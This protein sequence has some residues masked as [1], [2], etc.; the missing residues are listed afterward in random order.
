MHVVRIAVIVLTVAIASCSGGTG[1]PST[2]QPSYGGKA[3]SFETTRQY[4]VILTD[5]HCDVCTRADKDHLLANSKIM[6]RVIELIGQAEESIEVAQF[7]FSRTQI[8]D[9]LLEA[10]NNGVEVR[11][12][13]N[14]GQQGRD[15]PS[16]R[17]KE[18]G[19]P[20]RFVEGKDNGSYIGLQHAKY[21]I[22]DDEIVVMGS[23]NWSSTG[24]S[25]NEENTIVLQSD[26]DDPM[27][28]AFRCYFEHMYNA[29]LQLAAGCSNDEVR[30]TPSTQPW[31]MIRDEIRGAQSSVD[32]LMHHMT[33]DDAVK[34]LAKAAEN[35]RRV[36]VI[37]NAEDIDETRGSRWDRLRA[38]GGEIRYKQTNSDLYQFMHDK[39]AI[40]DGQVL[41]GGSGNWSG[42]AFFNNYEFYT[43]IDDPGVLVPFNGLFSRL[44][45]WSLTEE[46]LQEGRTAR[47]QD[48]LER[49]IYFGN[50][51]AHH[52]STQGED[53]LD[54]GN[55][56]REIDGET[57][58]ASVE[59]AGDPVRHAFEYAR[60]RGGLDFMALSPHVVDDRADDPPD[61]ASMTREGYQNIIETA[62]A[63]TTES[64]GTFVALPSFEWS[65]NSLGNHVNVLGSAEISKVERGDFKTFYE[66]F[67]ALRRDEGDRAYLM[68]NHPRTFRHP[69]NDT[70]NGSWDQI[71]GVNLQEI[72]RNS[73]RSKKFN[74]YGLDDYEP[75]ASV[76]P[77]WIAGE[78]MPD[79]S[80]VRE[81][82]GNIAQT[83][84]AHHRL[85]EVTINRGSGLKTEMPV[86]PSIVED[87]ETGELERYIKVHSD[88]DY[89]LRNGF[90]LAPVA[91][92]DNH[93]A[94]W[95]TAHTS[96]TAIIAPELTEDALLDAI[97]ERAVYASEDENLEVRFY[98]EDRVRAGNE[99]VTIE[100]SARLQFHL[101]DP[102][103]DGPYAVKLWG[104]T[105]GADEVSVVRDLGELAGGEWHDIEVE[106][107]ADGLHF[108][109]LEIHEVAPDRMAWSAPIW[110]DRQSDGA[111]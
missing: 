64:E 11:I 107:G 69:D 90:R 8:E 40:I 52:E 99:L 109:Y 5:P 1:E 28:G 27:V 104:G 31:K 110:I 63:V 2:Y 85:M 80:I 14:H 68:F 106:T 13:M 98:A 37:V 62:A 71:F 47:E 20:V 33:W 24:V 34:E 41:L 26:E 54:D 82:M 38:A 65:T 100:P 15:N 32:V 87:Y 73:D 89:F 51:H 42:G 10:H 103:F 39:L 67:L 21:M 53:L 61:I 44:W 56:E 17:L 16:T 75:L 93:Y 4:E 29:Q 94:N 22:V 92:H 66:G 57:V 18:A 74:D 45:S 77:S 78:A 46:S 105:V 97:G 79:E 9:A 86:N 58:D 60:E 43:R 84:S 70:L 12:A 102:D 6:A 55:L 76:L 95:G 36:R 111:N 48:V 7:T 23:N 83:T 19:V 81:T 49:E 25:I 108:F 3:D 50:L 101:A 35:G 59:A 91:S 88:W 96:R 72:E 30:F